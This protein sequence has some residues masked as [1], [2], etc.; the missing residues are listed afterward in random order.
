MFNKENQFYPTPEPLI[1]K[2]LSNIDF[3]SRNYSR[4]LEPSC[5]N[6]AIADY[7]SK[8][9]SH[10]T[11]DCIEI[12]PQLTHIL[13]G[14]GYKV[15]HDDFLTFN[16]Y[17]AYDCIFMNPPFKNA[18]AHIL[19]AIELIERRGGYIRC[20]LNAETIRNPYSNDRKLLTH[21]IEQY[22]GEVEFVENGFSDADRT[23]DVEVAIV[24]IDIPEQQKPSNILEN[25]RREQ[26]QQIKESREYNDLIE[27]DYISGVISQYNL[28]I[29]A[30]VKLIEEHEAFNRVNLRSFDEG[31]SSSILTMAIDGD[32]R[33]ATYEISELINRFIQNTRSK[34]WRT[35]FNS[36]E[37]AKLFTSDA[38]YE[39]YD[40]IEELKH[41]DFTHYNIKQI[42]EDLS[43]NM[44][45]MVEDEIMKLFNDWTYEYHYGENARTIHYYNG[46]K[47]N[48]AKS[49][50]KKVIIR[51]NA[52]DDYNGSFAPMYGV[53]DKLT[54]IEK[55]FNYLS[56]G[57]TSK[58]EDVIDILNE[59]RE[60]EQTKKVELNHIVVD[61]YKK[62]S[63][64]ITFK[65]QKIVDKMNIF[66]GKKL[67]WLPP[68]FGDKDYKDMDSESKEVVKSF[69]GEKK[70]GDIVTNKELYIQDASQLLMLGGG[71]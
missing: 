11:V 27:G 12:D 66:A 44:V 63:A 36:R 38:R 67:G 4:V 41:Y 7:I 39:Y 69:C 59:A 46:W 16:T 42:Q 28:E 54:D 21:K 35:L 61:F 70:Y 23:T 37:F 47:T 53:K 71:M 60:S 14:K 1:E 32:Q 51:L 33:G 19:H 40:K 48:K 34:Y 56:G 6:G 62:G 2:L 49:V 45:G 9:A 20:I 31:E 55:V 29:K 15:I 3:R 58:I 43:R 13:K 52:F 50:G 5:G 25:L 18:S 8:Q 68:Y 57:D 30:G 65:N 64:H 22:N 10:I 26:E 17:K 24:R